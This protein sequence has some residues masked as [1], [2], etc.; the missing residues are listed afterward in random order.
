MIP[1]IIH[2]CW[3]GKN[4]LPDLAVK[5]INS[6]KKYFPDYK[7]Q[8]WNEDNFDLDSC[9][10]CREA[11]KGKKWAFVS[12]YARFKILYEYGGIYFDTDV[13]VI[14]NMDDIISKGAF[15]GRE[16]IAGSFPVNAGLGIAAEKNMPILKEIIDDYERSKFVQSEKMETVVE[17]VTRILNQHGLSNKQQY[18]VIEGFHVYPSD[19]FCP[20]DYNIG[21]LCQTSN[22]RSI[23]WY[24][25]SWLDDRM[26]KRRKICVK[27]Q[28]TFPGGVG[29]KIAKIYTS[30][31]YYWEWVSTGNYK[32]I[33][34]KLKQKIFRYN[35]NGN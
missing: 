1:K 20:Y 15:I 4:P 9:E 24:D 8:E 22:T 3:F 33:K 34:S 14:R 6:W 32:M 10:Y 29:E 25:A 27:I 12:D 5:C 7:I 18:E 2:Y 19:Y 31:S 13:E 35:D 26:K 21:K 28:R 30:C 17:R 11:Y 23:H 16:R